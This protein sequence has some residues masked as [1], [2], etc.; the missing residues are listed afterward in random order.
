MRMKLT[1]GVMLTMLAIS[2]GSASARV[3]TCKI[4][5]GCGVF[6]ARENREHSGTGASAASTVAAAGARDAIECSVD[7][8]D[9]I[10]IGAVALTPGAPAANRMYAATVPGNDSCSGVVVMGMLRCGR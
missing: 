1:I 3:C 5:H 7:Q 8:G 10:E 2:S 4:D 6:D 9:K